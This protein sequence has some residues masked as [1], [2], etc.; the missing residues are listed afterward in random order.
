MCLDFGHGPLVALGVNMSGSKNTTCRPENPN[1]MDLNIHPA[2]YT[3][4]TAS[5]RESQRSQP[6]AWSRSAAHSGRGLEGTMKRAR[7]NH[8]TAVLHWASI[9]QSMDLLIGS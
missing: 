8:G 3:F 4:L 6:E 7:N 2:V 1:N 9:Q 5:H